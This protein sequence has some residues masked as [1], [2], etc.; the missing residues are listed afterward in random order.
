MP[1][2][3]TIKSYKSFMYCEVYKVTEWK[4][5]AIYKTEHLGFI[6]S[7]DANKLPYWCITSSISTKLTK[8]PEFELCILTLDEILT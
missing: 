4:D 2:N 7:K 5:G 6:E 8:L 3:V 1:K